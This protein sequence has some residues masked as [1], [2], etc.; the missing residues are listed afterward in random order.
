MLFPDLYRDRGHLLFDQGPF[1][2][3]GRVEEEFGAV[4]VTITQLERLDRM[5]AKLEGR[6]SA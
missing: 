3:R 6:R 4:T 1:I 2:F 5:L